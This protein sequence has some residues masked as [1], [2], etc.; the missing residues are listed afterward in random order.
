V[1]GNPR[2]DL[3]R[4]DNGVNAVVETRLIWGYPS[5]EE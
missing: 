4:N 1:S 3:S 2:A 5:A